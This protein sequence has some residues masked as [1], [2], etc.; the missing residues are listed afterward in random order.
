LA[1]I[2]G[3]GFYVEVTIFIL[4]PVVILLFAAVVRAL[5]TDLGYKV[6]AVVIALYFFWQR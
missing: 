4:G 3:R 2:K 5:G 6:L 1:L